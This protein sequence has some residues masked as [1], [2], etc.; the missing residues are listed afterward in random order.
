MDSQKKGTRENNSYKLC[1]VYSTYEFRFIL[2]TND[3]DNTWSEKYQPI[4]NGK[5]VP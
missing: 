1:N 3:S 5:E 2:D 4:I